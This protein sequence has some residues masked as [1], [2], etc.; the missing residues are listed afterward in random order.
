[1]KQNHRA[2]ALLL[3]VLTLFSSCSMFTA[4][5]RRQRAYEHYVRKSSLSRVKQQQK[6]RFGRETMPVM[7]PSEPIE[8]TETGS[9]PES[10][11]DGN[12]SG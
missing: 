9:G 2:V 3:V 4:N 5:G 7:H 1:M 6:F 11:S 10:V 8:T 12:E